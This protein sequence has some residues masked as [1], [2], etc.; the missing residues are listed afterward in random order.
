MYRLGSLLTRCSAPAPP[1]CSL[2]DER[3]QAV[4][5][6]ATRGQRCSVVESYDILSVEIRLELLQAIDV[7][8]RGPVDPHEFRRVESRLDGF[9]GL[10][11]Q[12][13]SPGGVESDIV[14]FRVYPVHF[15]RSQEVDPAAGLHR[16][17]R[18][19]GLCGP[20]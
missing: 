18:S 13:L 14:A 11:Q 1:P 5:V 7:D 4:A 8:Y 20:C 9:D 6:A 15:I 12:V 17:T 3:S 10:P 19:V 16:K 2:L